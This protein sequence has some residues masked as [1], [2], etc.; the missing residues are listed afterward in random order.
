MKRPI[1]IVFLFHFISVKT[2]DIIHVPLYLG[3]V[4][5]QNVIVLSSKSENSLKGVVTAKYREHIGRVEFFRPYEDSG[6]FRNKPGEKLSLVLNRLAQ[7]CPDVIVCFGEFNYRLAHYLKKKFSV[8]LVIVMEYLRPDKIYLPYI[9]GRFY[10]EKL[11]IHLRPLE[12]SFLFYL[13]GISNYIIFTYY[14][15]KK[16]A[17]YLSGMFN[18]S[19]I[20]WCT[21]INQEY[22]NKKKLQGIYVG[23]LRHFKNSG[24]LFRNIPI[25]LENTLIERF[26]VVGPGPYEKQINFLKGKYGKRFRYIHSLNRARALKMIQESYF[27]YTPVKDC[28]LGFLGDCWGSKTPIITR[29]SL[30]GFLND[31]LDVLISKNSEEVVENV[32]KLMRDKD[33]YKVLQKNGYRRYNN[34]QT[35]SAVGEQYYRILENL[36]IKEGSVT[37]TK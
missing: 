28:G 8:P 29:Y 2:N 4:K 32:N 25:I 35:A 9:R 34:K 36:V 33:L 11:H 18:L 7:F 17:K 12:Y 6:E 30:D 37:F 16:L 20:P 23:G 21:Q 24:E 26:I 13:L 14:G 5:K 3:N 22:N 15:D 10:L 1:N 19:Y 31:N 27:G